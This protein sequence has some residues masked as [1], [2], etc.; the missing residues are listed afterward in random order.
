MFLITTTYYRLSSSGARK[1]DIVQVELQQ[2][3]E[4]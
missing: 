3:K 4:E 2:S 1:N